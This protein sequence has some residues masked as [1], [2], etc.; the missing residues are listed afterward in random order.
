MS[1]RSHTAIALLTLALALGAAAVPV[2]SHAADQDGKF[3]QNHSRREQVNQRLA[4]QNQRIKTQVAEGDL[5]KK[6]A[7]RLHR[8]HRQIRREERLMASQH[9]GHITKAEQRVLNQQENAVSRQI[10]K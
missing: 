3:A 7:A 2:L 1:T 9:G 4:N 10:G 6:Q 5:T 8:E